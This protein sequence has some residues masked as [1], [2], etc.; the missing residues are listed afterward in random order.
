MR[1]CHLGFASIA[2]LLACHATDRRTSTPAVSAAEARPLLPLDEAHSAEFRR[3]FDEAK[4]RPR[5][6]VAL[7]PT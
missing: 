4:D 6:I 1:L 2:L 3:L 7:S 5:Y